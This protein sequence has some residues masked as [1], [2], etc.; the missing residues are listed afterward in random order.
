MVQGGCK[1]LY[2]AYED[3]NCS[4]HIQATSKFVG[5]H[6]LGFSAEDRGSKSCMRPCIYRK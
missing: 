3:C 1:A 2:R 6:D 4:V 5:V